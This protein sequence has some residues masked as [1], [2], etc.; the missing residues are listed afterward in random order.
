MGLHL[1]PCSARPEHQPLPPGATHPKDAPCPFGEH[2]TDPRSPCCS[3]PGNPTVLYLIASDLATLAI[4][5]YRD[6]SPEGAVDMADE[7]RTA[8][9]SL[10]RDVTE[11]W[12]RTSPPG[13]K[14]T[15]DVT[16]S[17]PS[18]RWSFE[19]DDALAELEA[20]ACWYEKIGRMGFGVKAWF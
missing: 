17:I 11:G 1:L 19:L 5:L 10:R 14:S 13:T 20:A 7:L 8:A 4:T 15:A 9:K 2:P 16:T 6:V 12:R 3:F 18:V